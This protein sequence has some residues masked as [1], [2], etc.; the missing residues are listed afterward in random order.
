MSLFHFLNCV[1]LCFLPHVVY[2][3]ATE[4]AEYDVWRSVVH[5]FVSQ[6]GT[7]FAKMVML[8]FL[9]PGTEVTKQEWAKDVAQILVAQIDMAGLWFALVS[10]SPHRNTSNAHRFQ[11]VGL[12]WAFA[13]SVLKRAAP[14]WLGGFS[15]E[16]SL[17]HVQAAL[18]S[19]IVLIQSL[20]FAAVGSLIWNKKS[21][22]QNLVPLLKASLFLH[23]VAPM[24]LSLT[25]Q[26]AHIPGFP[27]LGME[28]GVS[29]VCALASWKL[30]S[31]C[32][33][34]QD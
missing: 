8:A 11:A 23:A 25:E 14:L 16:F 29:I 21:K 24:A 22:P 5:G 1:A 18:R 17:E 27:A 32:T 3:N 13:D 20:S 19:N 15:P 34:K 31:W 28:L 26:Y 2:Y 30:Y 33:S 9:L 10:K 6:L 4:L 12:G 7:S